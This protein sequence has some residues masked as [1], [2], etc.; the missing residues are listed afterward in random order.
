M[1]RRTFQSLVL[2]SLFVYESHGQSGVTARNQAG[3]SSRASDDSDYVEIPPD[4]GPETYFTITY[5]AGTP[6]EGIPDWYDV[7]EGDGFA[8]DFKREFTVS[9]ADVEMSFPFAFGLERKEE[10]P[11]FPS[12]EFTVE[13]AEER[14]S[15]LGESPSLPYKALYMTERVTDS[16]VVSVLDKLK[17]YEVSPANGDDPADIAYRWSLGAVTKLEPVAI[18]TSELFKLPDSEADDDTEYG[19]IVPFSDGGDYQSSINPESQK[20][21]YNPRL[22]AVYLHKP[23][24]VKVRLSWEPADALQIWHTPF[25]ART[26]GETYYENGQISQGHEFVYKDSDNPIFVEAITSQ[27]S[28]LKW[29]IGDSYHAIQIIPVDMAVDAN[30]DGVISFAGEQP[31]SG[32]GS[33]ERTTKDKPFRFWV[34]GDDDSENKDHPGSGSKDSNSNTIVS[35]RDLE[36][37]ARLHLHVGGLH[38]AIVSGTVSVGLEWKNV[39]SN[40]PSIKVFAAASVSGG[41]GYLNSILDAGHQATG[42]AATALGTVTNGGSFRFPK[43]FWEAD[44]LTGKPALSSTNP[45]RH[46]IFEGVTKGEGALVLKFWK[47]TTPIGEGPS[48]NLKLVDV[49]EMYQSSSE[50]VFVAPPDES[51]QAVIFVHGWNMSPAGSRNFAETMFKRLWHRGFKGRLAYFRWDTDWSDA[52]DNVPGVGQAAEAYFADYNKS[53][54]E[55]WVHGGSALASFVAEIPENYTKNIAAHSMGNIVVG[56]ALE[57]GMTVNNYAMMQAAVP[58]SSYDDR[59]ILEQ[60][61]PVNHAVSLNFW[62]QPVPVGSITVWDQSTPDGDT[63]SATRALAYRGLLQTIAQR[64]N[65]ISFYLPADNATSYAWEI[66]NGLTKPPGEWSNQYRYVPSNPA[67]QRL[68]K[69]YGGGVRDYSWTSRYESMAFAASSWGKAVGAEPRTEGAIVAAG[70]VNLGSSS[71]QL[72]GEPQNSGFGNQHSGQFNAPIQS[73]KLFYDELINTLEVGPANP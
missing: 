21:I 49:R 53:E 20:P 65:P 63:D 37:F 14:D 51:E 59:T 62:G 48:I 68:Y 73:L 39:T 8:K 30:R 66:N 34:N 64:C 6:F 58:A 52:F 32:S 28:K 23:K 70:G 55:A 71:F 47:G 10:L 24:Q 9:F 67:G 46:I 38:D 15:W 45:N 40:A 18:T 72:P 61:Q 13:E 44:T 57:N 12:P 5:N 50:N 54:Y 19:L 43:T 69:E 29:G 56:S 7:E 27:K 2:M 11:P 41:N 31:P 4:L 16:T 22:R 3:D 42:A 17:S 60:T 1:T 36:D 25:K 26:D 33:I 35:M